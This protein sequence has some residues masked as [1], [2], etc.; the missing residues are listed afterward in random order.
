MSTLLSTY[1]FLVS[2][3]AASAISLQNQAE[4]VST[5]EVPLPTQA[6]PF[7]AS[8]SACGTVPAFEVVGVPTGTFCKL[9]I[10]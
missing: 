10:L 3:I 9:P 6:E 5:I 2:G 8:V 1:A 7:T 4:A